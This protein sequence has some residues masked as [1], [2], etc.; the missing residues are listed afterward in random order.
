MHGWHKCVVRLQ[1]GVSN[2]WHFQNRNGNLG[3]RFEM[4]HSRPHN[5]SIYCEAALASLSLKNRNSEGQ[6]E[7]V[8]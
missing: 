5:R 4:S 8:D 1:Y 6:G 2:R 7:V 3:L